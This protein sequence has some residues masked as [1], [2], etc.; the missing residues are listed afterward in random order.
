MSYAPRSASVQ[1]LI[2]NAN[3]KLIVWFLDGN[4]RTQ[5][6]RHNFRSGRPANNP[7]AVEIRRHERSVAK[8]VPFIRVAIIYDLATGE[9]V[10]RFKRGEWL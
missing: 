1:R 8:N 2:D 6:G 5:Y 3:T 7:R 4:V 10:S 9:E